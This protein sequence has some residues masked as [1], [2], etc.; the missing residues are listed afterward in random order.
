MP[1]ATPTSFEG[2]LDDPAQIAAF[3]DGRGRVG[4]EIQ[5]EVHDGGIVAVLIN[6]INVGVYCVG[7]LRS[8][9][10]DSAAL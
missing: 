7:N 10:A 4:D 9:V 2:L 6:I 3:E 5:R 1:K 8:H